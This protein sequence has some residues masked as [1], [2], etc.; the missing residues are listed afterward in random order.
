[1]KISVDFLCSNIYNRHCG[2]QKVGDW[3][4]PRT[5]RPKTENPKSVNVKVRFDE[6]LHNALISYCEKKSIT[7]TEAIRQAVSMLLKSEK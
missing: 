6:E 1:M 7:R 5:G 3:F 2:T 4:S